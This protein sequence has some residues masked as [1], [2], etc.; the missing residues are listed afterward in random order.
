MKSETEF[1]LSSDMTPPLK[2][3]TVNK[4]KSKITHEECNLEDLWLDQIP[5]LSTF[6]F[7]KRLVLCWNQIDFL[8][9][10]VFEQLPYL[11]SVD[12]SNN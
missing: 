2:L 8:N 10:E 11:E 7:I 1:N 5:D 3:E 9:D 12:A 6:K 4:I